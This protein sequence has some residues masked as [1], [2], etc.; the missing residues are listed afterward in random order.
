[1]TE[2]FEDLLRESGFYEIELNKTGLHYL[3]VTKITNKHV[4][5][6][7]GM[8]SQ[9]V[10]PVEEIKQSN[11]GEIN[12]S[13][14]D[15]I[16]VFIDAYDNGYGQPVVSFFKA[17]AELN[18]V[19][20]NRS[21]K[22]KDFFLEVIGSHPTKVGIVAK[23]Y[24]TEIFIPYTLLGFDSKN[25]E[26]YDDEFIGSTFKVKVIKADFQKNHIVSSHKSYLE[27]E[28][29]L[30]FSKLIE[31]MNVGDIHEVFLNE[32]KFKHYGVFI[33]VNHI[34]TLLKINDISWKSISDPKEFFNGQ[35]KADVM[36]TGIDH[37]KERIY[38]SHKL[39]NTKEWD[40]FV[41]N[42]NVGENIDVTIVSI[43]DDYIL[44]RHNDSIDFILHQYEISD[45]GIGGNLDLLYSIG[46]K[47][48]ATIKNI[49]K[50]NFKVNL[51]VKDIN[52][53]NADIQKGDVVKGTILSKGDNHTGIKVGFNQ[54]V[55]WISKMEITEHYNGKEIMN[56][57]KCGQ[58]VEFRVT[59]AESGD[60]KGS[61]ILDSKFKKYNLKKG[62]S[63]GGF[64]VIDL[65]KGKVMVENKDGFRG[66]VNVHSNV[67]IHPKDIF[68]IDDEL[69][70][71]I[72]KS[73]D[74]NNY[75][76][77]DYF[78]QHKNS[79]INPKIGDLIK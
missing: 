22:E 13:I 8:K 53:K 18:R 28:K 30:S 4:F 32:R 69:S 45:Q 48:K 27:K 58:E 26:A 37:E 71:L 61:L 1:M 52:E 56:D 78:I 20:I 6:D 40:D 51:S 35:K 34:D 64:K 14:D 11:N 17:R 38:V 15:E 9:G 36:I 42:H 74:R 25:K 44:V 66:F 50:D 39:A 62:D 23:Y 16:P 79:T 19:D 57:M 29:G 47:I 63:V 31:N 54:L 5:V 7:V 76:H 24:N 59:S 67:K 43:K 70:D 21:L 72:F 41:N 3:P 68:N 77:F 46:D 10:I 60:F 65:E 2:R 73:I 49:D 33:S 55:F 75:F 12:F